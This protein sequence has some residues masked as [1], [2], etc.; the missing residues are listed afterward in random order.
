[1]EKKLDLYIEQLREVKELV[2]GDEGVIYS[3]T[4]SI[5]DDKTL[6]ILVGNEFF[7]KTILPLPGEIVLKEKD[8]NYLSY[9]VKKKYKSLTFIAFLSD[10]EIHLLDATTKGE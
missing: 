1:M 4:T 8:E 6:D 9:Y 2:K 3:V 5:K 7:I 10:D